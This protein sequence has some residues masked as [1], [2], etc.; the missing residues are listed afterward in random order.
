M[1]VLLFMLVGVYLFLKR[2][3]LTPIREFLVSLVPFMLFGGALRAVEDSFVAAQFAGV[4]PPIQFPASALLI[5]PFIYF[6]VFVIAL[7]A[8]LVS[9][10]LEHSGITEDFQ[11]PLAVF[12]AVSFLAA[13]GYIAFLSVTTDYVLSFPMVTVVT[14]GVASALALGLYYG[15][16]RF[17]PEYNMGTGYVGLAVLWA[18]AIDGVANVIASDWTAAFGV[19][20]GGYSAKHVVNRAIIDVTT[21]IQPAAVTDAIGDSWTFL[22]VKLVVAVAIIAMFDEEFI[23][24]SK[25]YAALLLTA[26]IAVG[27]GPGT[28]DM[29]RVTFGI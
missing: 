15:I 18:H 21:L 2:F 25:Y 19:P 4:T 20:G 24:D 12:G 23:E 26:I 29:I 16:E 14:V 8:F 17:K 28:R 13:F 1:V 27:L 6:T 3:D 5:S 11:R 10:W 9:K 7:G 22:A